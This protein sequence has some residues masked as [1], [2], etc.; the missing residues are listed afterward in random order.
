MCGLCAKLKFPDFEEFLKQ[1]DIICLTEIKT[2]EYGEVNIDGFRFISASRA[3]AK[4]K[5]GGVG[6]FVKNSIWPFVKIL[7]S[8]SE[9]CLWFTLNDYYDLKCVL[10]AIYIPPEGSPYS[11]ASIFDKI[12][13]DIINFCADEN[14]YTC[15]MGDFNARSGLLS[16]FITIDEEIGDFALDFE[17]KLILSK[18]NLKELGFPTERFSLEISNTNNYGYRLMELCK[19]LDVH[20]VNGRCGADSY[21]GRQTCKHSSV[22]DYVIMSAELFPCIHSFEVLEFDPLLSDIHCPVAFTINMQLQGNV[23]LPHE[24]NLTT[25]DNNQQIVFFLHGNLNQNLNL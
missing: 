2:D 16:D 17:S 23:T 12:E 22:I 3:V 1:Y 25:D 7:D 5:S 14:T 18:N 15:L 24:D 19:S 21:I 20:I 13:Q 9:N 8:S 4:R 11:S 10:G 6:L